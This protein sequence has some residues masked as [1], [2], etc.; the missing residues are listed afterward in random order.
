MTNSLSS[1]S[2]HYTLLVFPHVSARSSIVTRED[3]NLFLVKAN[4]K[5]NGQQQLSVDEFAALFTSI[6]LYE[7]IHS[8]F[9]RMHFQI[10][11]DKYS[12]HHSNSILLPH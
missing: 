8:N 7:Y 2:Y 6:S 5:G 10:Q 1:R 3:K 9:F 11:K 12:L 4:K